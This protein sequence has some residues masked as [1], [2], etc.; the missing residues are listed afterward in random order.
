[1]D[2]VALAGLARA[3]TVFTRAVRNCMAHPPRLYR[4]EL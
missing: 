2:L 4:L 3:K 1:M